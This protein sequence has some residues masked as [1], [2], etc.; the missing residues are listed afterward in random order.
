MTAAQDRCA[1]HD[2]SESGRGDPRGNGNA[3]GATHPLYTCFDILA[4]LTI[5]ALTRLTNLLTHL[6]PVTAPPGTRPD[7]PAPAT[8]SRPVPAPALNAFS[9]MHHHPE[10]TPNCGFAAYLRGDQ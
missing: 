3:A 4:G 7:L 5:R 6:Q 1:V 2:H 10:G 8:S 9:A